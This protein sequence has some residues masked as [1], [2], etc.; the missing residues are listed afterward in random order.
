[1]SPEEYRISRRRMIDAVISTDM[2][3][4]TKVVTAAKTK[5]ELYDIIKGKNF[6]KIFEDID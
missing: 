4:H 2:A 6:T 3:K 5:T 1:M